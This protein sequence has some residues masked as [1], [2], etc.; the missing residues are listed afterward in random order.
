MFLLLPDFKSTKIAR[1]QLAYFQWSAGRPQ[2]GDAKIVQPLFAH[3]ENRHLGAQAAAYVETL[4]KNLRRELKAELEILPD[5][6]SAVKL[7]LT[8]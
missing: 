4:K 1:P 5:S 6:P 7:V 3:V 8:N 2:A